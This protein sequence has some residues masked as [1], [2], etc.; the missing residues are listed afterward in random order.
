MLVTIAIS[1]PITASADSDSDFD[2][3]NGELISY[4]GA[5]G[6][7]TI[8]NDVTSIG[9]SAFYSAQGA[10]VTSITI[11]NSVTEID[12]YAFDGCANITSVTIPSSVS[13][14]GNH[15][16]EKC[17]NLSNVTFQNSISYL[18][19]YEFENC[20][21]LKNIAIPNGA[22]VIG[23]CAFSNCTSLSSVTIPASVTTIGDMAFYGCTNLKAVTI[24]NTVTSI[25][26]I[27]FSNCSKD[28]II[29]CAAD[30]YAATY[31]ASN[32]LNYN[33]E[34]TSISI[35]SKPTKAY[36]KKGQKLDL[37]GGMIKA[38]YADGSTKSI[39]MT[40][41][42]VS[43]FYTNYDGTQPIVFTYRGKTCTIS[44]II[45][46]TPP[47][48]TFN[49]G[50][51]YTTLQYYDANYSSK[52]LTLNGKK[53]AWPSNGHVSKKGAYKAT[54]TDKAGNSKSVTFKI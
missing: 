52:T 37:T 9:D 36:Y 50:Q 53:V 35:A 5:G 23:D 41:F 39:P 14:M 31:A 46:V 30:S 11:P 24:P 19:E 12:D 54:V 25:G 6:A 29:D 16:F 32:D 38:K 4:N 33:S 7:V 34:L 45:D 10:T 48:V 42:T 15:I 22:T 40:E 26:S 18:G 49:K 27:V 8:P 2:V 44:V 28:L 47:R 20:T 1:V 13:K 43:G 21:S 51:K 3:Y 17:T